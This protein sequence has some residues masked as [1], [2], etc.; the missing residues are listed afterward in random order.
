MKRICFYVSDYGFGHA[1][2]QI[3]LLRSLHQ[4]TNL[5][6]FVK[7]YSSYDFITASFTGNRIHVLKQKNDLGPSYKKSMILDREKTKREFELYV[8]NWPAYI[9]KEIEFL[10]KRKIDLVISDVV[11]QIAIAAKKIGLPVVA[12]TNFTWY[13]IYSNIL[14]ESQTENLKECYEMMDLCLALPFDMP[15]EYFKEKEKTNLLTR[16]FTR[17]RKNIRNKLNIPNDGFVIY[18][19]IGFSSNVTRE[20][21]NIPDND[22]FLFLCSSNCKMNGGFTIPITDV[23]SQDY[24]SAADLAVTKTAYGTVSE[25]INGKVP[26]CFFNRP[27]FIEGEKIGREI[28]ELNIGKGYKYDEIINHSYLDEFQELKSLSKSYDY[29][30]ERFNNLGANQATE[31]IYEFLE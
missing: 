24:I 14:G 31:I 11:P 4:H 22:K 25:A 20:K 5:E 17:S 9:K 29:L 28:E 10:R 12:I 18:F 21:F 26:L 13:D 8:R 19:G 6:L 1:S 30:P 15:L 3:A 16:N 27:N 7:S 2:R 23:E